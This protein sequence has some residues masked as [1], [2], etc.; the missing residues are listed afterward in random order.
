MATLKSVATGNFTSS[1]T[2]ALCDST[3]ELDSEASSASSST[4]YAATSSFTPGAITVQAICVKIRQIGSTG[5][6]FSTELYNATL[7]ASVAGT[8]VTIDVAD[9]PASATNTAAVR[10]SLWLSMK[11][12]SP[13]TL[14]AATNYQVR[15]KSSLAASVSLYRDA[16]TNNWS[17]QLVT[18]TNQAPAAGDKL[19]VIGEKTGAGASTSYTV[20]M[21][22]TAATDYGTAST[23]IESIW[24]GHNATMSYGTAS[25]TNYILRCS[26]LIGVGFGGTFNIGTTG[27][28][29]PR[30]S[31]A[32][33]EFDCAA[34]GDFG[35]RV[36]NGTF[37]AQGLS[38]TSGKDVIKCLLN[39]DAATSATSLT[40]TADTGWLS[41]DTIGIAGTILGSSQSE[42]RTLSVDAGASTLTISSG[43]TNAKDGNSLMQAEIVLLTKNVM[44]RSVS[45]TAMCY[46]QVVGAN[47]TIDCDWVDFRY[48]GAN[49]T[50]K[51]GIVFSATG[52][53]CAF[54]F[55][56][57][58]NGE[59]GAFFVSAAANLT[60]SECVAYANGTTAGNTGNF[61]H[62]SVAAIGT[63]SVTDCYVIAGSGYNVF[64]ASTGMTLTGCRFANASTG[65]LYILD[66]TNI[67]G[68]IGTF[69]NIY[70][71]SCVNGFTLS[72]RNATVINNATS[73]RN[74]AAGFVLGMHGGSLTNF[75]SIGNLNGLATG[76]TPRGV[77]LKSGVVAGETGYG[78]ATGLNGTDQSWDAYFEDVT[79]GVVTASNTAHS[80]S[81]IALGTT[82]SN[83]IM[84]RNCILASTNEVSN[85]TN[86]GLPSYVI[87][88]R[89][90][91][92]SG[93][94][95]IYRRQGTLSSDT[96][97]FSGSSPSYR[98]TPN[99]T[100]LKFDHTILRAAVASG[101]AATVSV[102]V[103]ESVVG[104]GTDYNGA[105]IR[106]I[107]KKNAAAGIATDTVL[108]TATSASEGAFETLTGTTATVTNDCVLEFCV[109]CDGTT[110]W[111]N[112]DDVTPPAAVSTLG[113]GAGDETIFVS[114][115]GNNT[116]GG[117][118]SSA[119]VGYAFV[120]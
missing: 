23:T 88:E 89:H 112:V 10:E 60:V 86:W 111:I 13:V 77:Y 107:V 92:T 62:S 38:R 52:G 61:F 101:T 102:K 81:D 19:I 120:N 32:V 105:R 72:Y 47:P 66:S 65:G 100:A 91:Q 109:D 51:T 24:I 15:I 70:V 34:D 57:F 42:E 17:R 40:V 69:D 6:T 21:D 49:V 16:T 110:G 78:Q 12:A 8:E 117:G 20:T 5:G 11:F 74:S 43:L 118:G 1:S 95:R 29:I 87:S 94:K 22:S 48:V 55:C 2:W 41:G 58:R 75:T 114:A 93:S 76:N 35:L 64:A 97:I 28:P 18:T 39:A 79:F 119:T 83:Q 73:K 31:T 4:A 7:G 54:N 37:V 115:Y 67:S 82:L 9:I 50:N 63:V 27:T 84:L 116:S 26:G 44:F 36:A 3:S 103:R 59:Y 45:T 80:T 106:L 68:S 30:D 46:A 113:L 33:L 25:A 90:D 53:S 108:A 85:Q 71:H 99:T 104:D 98:I 96:T 14:L 56:S